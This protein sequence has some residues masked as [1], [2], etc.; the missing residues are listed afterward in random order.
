MIFIRESFGPNFNHDKDKCVE[1]SWDDQECWEY[2]DGNKIPNGVI[3]I[4]MESMAEEQE[5]GKE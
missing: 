4:S 5:S 3:F 2:P 1:Q